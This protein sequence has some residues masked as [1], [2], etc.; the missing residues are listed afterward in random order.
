[1]DLIRPLRGRLDPMVASMS[2]VVDAVDTLDAGADN[3]RGLLECHAVLS[4][5]RIVLFG[6]YQDAAQRTITADMWLPG[7]ATQR[8]PRV[9][10]GS[11]ARRHQLW[12]YS[13]I[14]DAQELA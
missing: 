11:V 5:G 8:Q 2:I 12:S 14:T 1:M 9:R 13:P 4:D 3:T 10:D 6:F 7:D